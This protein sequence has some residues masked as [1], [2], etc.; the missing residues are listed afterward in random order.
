MIGMVA[1][2]L[3]WNS[4]WRDSKSCVYL[5]LWYAKELWQFQPPAE[6]CTASPRRKE[7]VPKV[8]GLCLLPVS[9]GERNLCGKLCNF[10][11]KS[12]NTVIFLA[13]TSTC[14]MGLRP[15]S[16]VLRVEWCR[17]IDQGALGYPPPNPQK[18]VGVLVCGLSLIASGRRSAP[19]RVVVSRRQVVVKRRSEFI[20]AGCWEMH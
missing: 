20:F 18:T 11:G 10:V 19:W 12:C 9:P 14:G 15:S 4:S 5:C 6:T 3:R 16:V 1:Q 2:L 13:S 7:D 8:F 17:A